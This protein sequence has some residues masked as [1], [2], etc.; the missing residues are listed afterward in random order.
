MWNPLRIFSR[1]SL[2]PRR[3]YGRL[4]VTSAF[5]AAALVLMLI[6]GWL[7]EGRGNTGAQDAIAELAR[8]ADDDPATAIANASRANRVVILS[9]IHESAATKRLAVQALQKIVATSGLDILALE[10]GSDLQPIIDRYLNTNPEDASLLVTNERALRAP[11]PATRGYLDI[12]RTVWKLNEKLGADRRIQII[13][14]DL[15]GWPP[16]SVAPAELAHKSAERDAHMQK[17]I[18]DVMGLNPGAR[19]LVFMTGYHALKGTTGQLQTGGTEPVQIA[20]LGDRLEQAAPEEVYSFLVDAPVAGRASDVTAYAGTALADIVKRSGVNRSF[21]TPVTS[22]LDAIRRPL[23][24][25][26]SPGL[27]F[28]LLPR[29]YKLSDVA[30]AYIFLR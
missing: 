10:V 16:R 9:D 6:V 27:S 23:V 5:A 8:E 13:A 20:W 18:R 12:Y 29:D 4:G 2:M 14:A 17:Q 30:D 22:E 19:V 25:R 7:L 28:E 3:K 21:V 11:G 1:R 26:K 24:A 15:E